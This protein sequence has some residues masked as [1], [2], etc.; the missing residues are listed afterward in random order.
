MHSLYSK[1]EC[2]T[3]LDYNQSK[4]LDNLNSK[5]QDRIEN[6]IL[7]LKLIAN[8]KNIS[9]NSKYNNDQLTFSNIK[10]N[11]NK[12]QQ[13]KSTKST[14]KK[15]NKLT[16]KKQLNN[17]KNKS[18]F[19]KVIPKINLYKFIKKN[20][21]LN[22]YITNN[23][24]CL[25]KNVSFKSEKNVTKKS[26]FDKNIISDNIEKNE[27]KVNR[28]KQNNESKLSCDFAVINN[29]I[30]DY[31]SFNINDLK[32]IKKTSIISK[33]KGL[34][35]NKKHNNVSKLD[36]GENKNNNQNI[37]YSNLNNAEK[38]NLAKNNNLLNNDKKSYI[39]IVSNSIT[40][41]KSM[42]KDSSFNELK[43]ISINNS[44]LNLNIDNNKLNN[45]LDSKNTNNK[46]ILDN[47][48]NHKTNKICTSNINLV[49]QMRYINKL[50]N[51]SIS[52]INK[53]ISQTNKEKY[54]K[55]IH[56]TSKYNNINKS[57][58]SKSLKKL[59]LK[60]IKK[61]FLKISENNIKNFEDSIKSNKFCTNKSL[62]SKDNKHKIIENIKNK[63]K[64]VTSKEVGLIEDNQIKSNKNLN[65]KSN[66][67]EHIELN[68]IIK[69]YYENFINNISYKMKEWIKERNIV[70]QINKGTIYDYTYD[71]KV[72]NIFNSLILKNI[73]IKCMDNIL[74]YEQQNKL[75]KFEIS[76]ISKKIKLNL[77]KNKIVNTNDSNIYYIKIPIELKNKNKNYFNNHKKSNDLKHNII[78]KINSSIAEKYGVS[79]CNTLNYSFVK[80]ESNDY[81][82]KQFKDL[83]SENNNFYNEV[84]SIS[85]KFHQKLLDNSNYIYSNNK[86]ISDNSNKDIVNNLLDKAI[87]NKKLLI[88]NI[89]LY[90]ERYDYNSNKYIK[91]NNVKIKNQSIINN[92]IYKAANYCNDDRYIKKIKKTSII[93]ENNKN[94][95][96]NP[97][98]NMNTDSKSNNFYFNKIIINKN[99]NYLNKSM[100]NVLSFINNVKHKN[101]NKSI[102]DEF[103]INEITCIKNCSNID[104]QFYKMS[105]LEKSFTSK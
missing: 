23:S 41:D 43:T 87:N 60:S 46:P 52:N 99:I 18:K 93:K 61:K 24:S 13:I 49:N 91:L 70:S 57:N 50:D 38:I 9:L 39:K 14:K 2:I 11:Y 30:L 71:I 28:K 32:S 45:L 100:P 63:N 77:K 37:N 69:S 74:E 47:L 94:K 59:K 15:L 12:I 97:K 88:K 21:S 92:L 101:Y 104:L 62:N 7:Q 1:L 66:K 95:I 3:N 76:Q 103:N 53:N 55:L 81:F 42:N 29:K 20:N 82:L 16:E 54:K 75:I 79:L 90:K 89:E 83:S 44:Y 8:D 33:D 51:D 84:L 86:Y 26:R 4:F 40:S 36:Y 80:N 68:M 67:I 78:S 19:N 72:Q 22:N 6:K 10:N 34:G 35:S 98:I 17:I 105:K 31:E 5:I 48:L 102:N 73:F 58:N 85:K 25:N 64:I 27:I 56:S 96:S 65:H